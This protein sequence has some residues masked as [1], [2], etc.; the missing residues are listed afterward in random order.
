MA[1]ILLEVNVQPKIEL[2]QPG[3]VAGVLLGARVLQILVLLPPPSPGTRF[4]KGGA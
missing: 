1:K 3:R 4:I 2:L